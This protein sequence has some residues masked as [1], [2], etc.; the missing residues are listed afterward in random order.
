MLAFNWAGLFA[1]SSDMAQPFLQG[2]DT[3]RGRTGTQY[4]ATPI[5]QR[6][7]ALLTKYE[8]TAKNPAR[9][10]PLYF[11]RRRDCKYFPVYDE[12]WSRCDRSSSMEAK[13]IMP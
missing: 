7:P 10:T 13:R 8:R 6:S 3:K 1:F 4:R 9:T 11:S 5:H 12:R 2:S